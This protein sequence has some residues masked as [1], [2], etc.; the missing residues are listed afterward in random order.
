MRGYRS[1]EWNQ[2]QIEKCLAL[3]LRADFR[4]SLLRTPRRESDTFV[5]SALPVYLIGA[6]CPRPDHKDK[7]SILAGSF[8]RLAAEVPL[9]NFKTMR[10]ILRYAR[11]YIHPLFET[12]NTD[13]IPETEEWINNINHP[14]KRKQELREAYEL[15][16][17]IGLTP[18]NKMADFISSSHFQNKIGLPNVCNSFIKDEPYDEEKALRWINSSLDIVKVAYGPISDKAM[19]KLIKHDSMIKKFL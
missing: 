11:R 8:K 6:A 10:K 19:E 14:E 17:V 13:Q 1:E 16:K 18:N 5:A 12:F 9:A 7:L 2:K 3:P 15:L 4:F